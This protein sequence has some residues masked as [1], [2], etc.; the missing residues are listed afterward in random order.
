VV[1]RRKAKLAPSGR[2]RRAVFGVY[3]RTLAVAESPKQIL[4]EAAV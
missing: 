1:R 4:R 2:Q 3:A